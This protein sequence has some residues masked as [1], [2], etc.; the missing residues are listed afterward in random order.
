MNT[1]NYNRITYNRYVKHHIRMIS[2]MT[3]YT[4]T[5]YFPSGRCQ[6][7]FPYTSQHGHGHFVCQ[8][9]DG[10][11]AE[12]GALIL[13]PQGHRWFAR[14]AQHGKVK[15][16]SLNTVRNASCRNS[17]PLSILINLLWRCLGNPYISRSVFVVLLGKE[18][19]NCT[20]CFAAQVLVNRSNWRH[21]SWCC[22]PSWCC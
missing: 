19:F 4:H 15:V 21:S 18:P 14:P 8:T 22:Y 1:W 16:C 9:D 13:S 11:S 7:G 17:Y 2:L 10:I 20:L 6:N 5:H 3:M 12:G